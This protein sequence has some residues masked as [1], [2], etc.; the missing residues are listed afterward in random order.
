[1]S[2]FYDPAVGIQRLYWSKNFKP[3]VPFTN[4]SRYA[5]PEVDRLLEAAAVE[6]DPEKR[7]KL[8]DNF[9]NVVVEDLPTLDLVT[10]SVITVYGRRVK[11]LETRVE[12][13]WSNGAG[14]ALEA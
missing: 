1:M 6:A 5:N 2:N 12:Q 8:F 9:Q 14:I 7:R 10:P 11:N 3:G 13:L 4:G